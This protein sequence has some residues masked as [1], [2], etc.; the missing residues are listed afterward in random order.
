MRKAIRLPGLLLAVG[1]ASTLAIACGDDEDRPGSGKAGSAGDA[2]AAG[3][4]GAGARAGSGGTQNRGGDPNTNL[5]GEPGGLA[6]MPGAAGAGG[7][8]GE[9]CS[10]F[11]DFVHQVFEAT[12]ED[13]EPT[14]IP[15]LCPTGP[16][17][18]LDAPAA[19]FDDLL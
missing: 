1:L 11:V 10:E 6:G 17:A 13:N 14:A 12:A 8:P 4:T 2:G 19:A 15:D 9:E 16:D 3:D 7:V 18:D 5:G